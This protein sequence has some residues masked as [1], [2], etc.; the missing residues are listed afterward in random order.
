MK[1]ALH[2]GTNAMTSKLSPADQ[3]TKLAHIRTE[4]AMERTLLAW[5]R[6]GFAFISAAVALDRI[7]IA[8]PS[9]AVFPSSDWTSIAW[10]VSAFISVTTTLLLIVATFQYLAQGKR[11]TAI[12]EDR[13]QI[14]WPTVIG[15][16]L[17]IALGLVAS[18]L[19][20]IF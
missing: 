20:L 3:N 6:T 11:V 10:M 16:Y 13:F 12:T 8:E 15:A 2:P 4:L 7:L 17:V 5:V 19:L 1:R 14:S 18:S 9:F